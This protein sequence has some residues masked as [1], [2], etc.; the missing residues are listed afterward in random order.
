MSN[1]KKSG[2]LGGIILGLGLFL[3]AFPL[4]FL[5][6]G[7]AVQTARALDEGAGLVISL[8]APTIEQANSGKLIHASGEVVT[9]DIL[10]DQMFGI[11]TNAIKLKRSV[12]MYQWEEVEEKRSEDKNPTYSYK[13]VWSSSTID[14]GGFRQKGYNNPGSFRVEGQSQKAGIVT[15]GEF[16]LGGNL[17]DMI[18]FYSNLN[19]T[20]ENLAAVSGSMKGLL[21]LIPNG[22]Y[23]G[24]ASGAPMI[25][26]HKITFS[27]VRPHTMSL[28]AKQVGSTLTAYTTTNGTDI[29]MI[30]DGVH[31]AESMFKAAHTRNTM[32]TWAIRVGGFFMMYIGLMMC[33]SPMLA[34]TSFIP[35]LGRVVENAASLVAGILAFSFSFITAASAW[36]IY[37]PVLGVSLLAVGGAALFAIVSMVN[38]EKKTFAPPPT[39]N[40]GPTAP[41]PPLPG[42]GQG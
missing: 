5:N 14:S 3:G 32:L 19:V 23:L 6:E 9:E 24:K 7:R 10:Q 1:N 35:V 8:P 40:A 29:L 16:S 12:Q 39:P 22:Y 21:H 4:L 20:D 26:D 33:M 41:P 2:G 27:Q 11:S 15:F 38:K 28:L 30:D 17:I 36:V 37:R 31:T 13:K 34:L 42:G 18:D 25:G